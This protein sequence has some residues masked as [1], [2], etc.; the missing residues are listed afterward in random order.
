M[1]IKT[2]CPRCAKAYNLADSL[3]GK[4]VRCKSCDTPFYVNGGEEEEAFAC[5]LAD[6][7]SPRK[8][9]RP[10]ARDERDDEDG[11]PRRRKKDQ[12]EEEAEAPRSRKKRKSKSSMG[13]VIGLVAGGGGLLLII[14]IVA[15]VLIL[16]GSSFSVEN[17]KKIRA[18]MTEQEVIALVGRPDQTL[19]M[20][21]FGIKSKSLIW[22]NRHGDFTVSML[23]GKVLTAVSVGK[24]GNMGINMGGGDFPQVNFPNNPMP[25]MQKQDWNK[26]QIGMTEQQVI[27]LFGQPA[28]NQTLEGIHVIHA[29]VTQQEVMGPNGRT[30]PVKKFTYFGGIGDSPFVY[31]TFVDGKVFKIKK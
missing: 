16:G 22:R 8:R 28:N 12:D 13:L 25:G 3:S 24:N 21:G 4:Q 1:P 30:K 15:L 20:G 29:N 31:V 17:F 18:G 2:A 26:L 23:N 7:E 9:S 19:D 5:E 6:E 27:A 10:S 14:L 11:R